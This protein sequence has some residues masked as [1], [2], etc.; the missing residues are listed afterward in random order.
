MI[1]CN[2]FPTE[3]E[4]PLMRS[5]R[6]RRLPVAI[7]LAAGF[8]ASTAAAQPYFYP[9]KGQSQQQQQQDRADCHVWAVQ[10][11]GFDPSTAS[12]SAPPP[13]P[14]PTTGP[15]RGAAR[16]AAIGA[17][18]GAIGG[19]AGK[20]AAIGAATGAV[21]GTMRRND[22]IRQSQAEQAQYSAQVGAQQQNYQRA[23]GS[24]MSGRGY[25]IQ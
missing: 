20:G 6:A 24:C 23:L 12:A 21:F 13:A 5:D 10:Q 17:V 2:R 14:P 9:Q 19:N 11:T 7:V 8:V 18:G 22:Q 4:E 16:G 15:G 25:S 3:T 1:D